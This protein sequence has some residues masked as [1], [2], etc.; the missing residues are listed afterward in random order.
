MKIQ[1]IL[2]LIFL[3]L[4]AFHVSATVTTQ[5]QVNITCDGKMTVYGGKKHSTNNVSTNYIIT[6]GKEILAVSCK[7]SK[8]KPWILASVSNGMITDPLW[9]CF[10]LR[11]EIFNGNPWTKPEFNDS[12]WAQA[13]A[14]F[15]NRGENPLGKVLDIKDE[16]L[17]IST[18]E[19]NP[20]LFCRRNLSDK[21]TLPLT[22]IR[23]DISRG[24]P[25]YIR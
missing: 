23:Q 22:A 4:F 1:N 2:H 20:K 6:P 21:A 16:A 12:H 5:L 14:G 17:W 24:M 18:A 7:N 19:D 11:N 13:V 3:G 15:S 8:S 25:E 10:S 9:K